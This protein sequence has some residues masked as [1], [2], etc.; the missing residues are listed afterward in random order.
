[1]DTAQR[2]KLRKLKPFCLVT[3]GGHLLAIPELRRYM[4]EGVLQ[5]QG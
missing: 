1:M 3:H 4:Q 5:V 2:P